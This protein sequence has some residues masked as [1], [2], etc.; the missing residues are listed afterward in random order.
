MRLPRGPVKVTARLAKSIAEIVVV[1]PPISLLWIT[2]LG[3]ADRA[4][5]G[6]TKAASAAATKTLNITNTSS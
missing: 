5:E 4:A 1:M 2:S 3:A 6:N